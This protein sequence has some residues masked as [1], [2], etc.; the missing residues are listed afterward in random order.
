MPLA[1]FGTLC[2]DLT[3]GLRRVTCPNGINNLCHT[4]PLQ[5]L[6]EIMSMK[7][8]SLLP[9]EQGK[10]TIRLLSKRASNDPTGEDRLEQ[11]LCYRPLLMAL[12]CRAIVTVSSWGPGVGNILEAELHFLFAQFVVS[13]S[14]ERKKS[15]LFYGLWLNSSFGIP[16]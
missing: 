11:W 5:V 10:V 14:R 16:L 13:H 9:S 7:V 6:N 15:Q 3:A 8:L 1:S 4:K 2:N 12:Y